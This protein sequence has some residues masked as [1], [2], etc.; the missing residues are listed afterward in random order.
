MEAL[1]AKNTH[2]RWA[3]T[4]EIE[5][6]LGITYF[7]GENGKHSIAMKAVKTGGRKHVTTNR[8]TTIL[9]FLALSGRRG[10]N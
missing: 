3:F 8:K 9:P 1:A 4:S 5:M 7:K 10:N 2:W 6:Y